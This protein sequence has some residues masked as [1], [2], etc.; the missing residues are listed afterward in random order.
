M[1]NAV[2]PSAAAS[3]ARRRN[4]DGATITTASDSVM[5]IVAWPLG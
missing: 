3:K 1:P 5:P 4:R 2:D